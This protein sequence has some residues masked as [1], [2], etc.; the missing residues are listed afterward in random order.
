M[1]NE[2][3]PKMPLTLINPELVSFSAELCD[4]DEGCLSVPGKFGKVERPKTVTVRAMDRNGEIFEITGEDLLAR[5]FCHEID[6]LDGALFVDKVS[7]Y[8][9]VDN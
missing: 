6:H 1:T 4:F 9:E 8:T 2:L 5:A 3:L 7:E